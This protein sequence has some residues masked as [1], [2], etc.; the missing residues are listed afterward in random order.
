MSRIWASKALLCACQT[1]A[2]APPSSEISST[3]RVSPTTATLLPNTL[4]APTLLPSPSP[5]RP[6]PTDTP[7]LKVETAMDHLP[8]TITILYNNVTYDP[9]VGDH[10]GLLRPG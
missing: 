5:T 10:L 1:K 4:E 6:S 2:T 8:L 7:L 9:L 3:A